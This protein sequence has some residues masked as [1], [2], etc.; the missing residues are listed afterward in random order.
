MHAST[1]SIVTIN[2]DDNPVKVTGSDPLAPVALERGLKV[3]KELEKVPNEQFPRVLS[4]DREE[5]RLSIT[6][7]RVGT[8]DLSDVI[9]EIPIGMVPQIISAMTSA[10]RTLHDRGFVHR[11][12]KP[13]N[14][15]IDYS[16]K[17]G[18]KEFAGIIDFGMTLR[19]NRK[20]NEP[21]AMGG[22][23]PYSHPSQR[24]HKELRAHPGQDWFA[25]A[26]TVAHLLI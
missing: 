18:I 10:L 9:N 14:F 3:L 16:G 5:G 7:T 19:I 2:S 6:M 12:L 23:R 24:E 26:R 22:T 17:D 13:G 11:D 20:Q 1:M 4:T 25:F 8:H 21:G 15:M